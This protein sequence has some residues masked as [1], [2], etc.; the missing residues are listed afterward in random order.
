MGKKIVKPRQTRRYAQAVRDKKAADF[1][2]MAG[3]FITCY[4]IR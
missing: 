2:A 1:N 3:M 4:S